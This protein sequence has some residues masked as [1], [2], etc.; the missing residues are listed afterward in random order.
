MR[1]TLGGIRQTVA[2]R[3]A[4]GE[5]IRLDG[6]FR[7]STGLG[8]QARRYG[9]GHG[10]GEDGTYYVFHD[11]GELWEVGNSTHASE[12]DTMGLKTEDFELLAA[13]TVQD[14]RCIELTRECALLNGDAARERLRKRARAQGFYQQWPPA[15]GQLV[16]EFYRLEIVG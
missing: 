10:Y 7:G 4:T 3:K 6:Y 2:R 12:G 13:V 11:D 16:G 8:M 9:Y 14:D 1:L 15:R 5:V